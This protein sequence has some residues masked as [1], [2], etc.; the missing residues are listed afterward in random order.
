[1]PTQQAFFPVGMSMENT[2]M[3]IC[4]QTTPPKHFFLSPPSGN[5]TS[6]ILL[7]YLVAQCSLSLS[8]VRTAMVQPTNLKTVWVRPMEPL[9]SWKLNFAWRL[10]GA[11]C[12][13][14]VCQT[15]TTFKKHLDKPLLSVWAKPDICY[16]YCGSQSQ[17]G[18]KMDSNWY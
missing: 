2:L 6:S 3:L 7:H 16:S 18:V 1:M 17:T 12:V 10:C 9:I 5:S 8:L 11:F 14:A 13:V 4:P 15:N